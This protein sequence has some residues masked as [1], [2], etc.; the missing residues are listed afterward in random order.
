MKAFHFSFSYARRACYQLPAISHQKLFFLLH[1][2][3]SEKNLK[4][5]KQFV[6]QE[7]LDKG[8]LEDSHTMLRWG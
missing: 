7:I 8:Y 6:L 2:C 5:G 4:K 3:E 1:C